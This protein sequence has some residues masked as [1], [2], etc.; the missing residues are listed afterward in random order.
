VR[1]RFVF[2]AAAAVAAVSSV[3]GC[4]DDKAPAK[5]AVFWLG[6]NTASGFT[7]SS[8]QNYQIPE[9]ARSIITSQSAQ[10]ERIKDDAENLVECDVRPAPGSSTDY[11]VSL[12]FSGGPVGNFSAN[13]TLSQDG[14]ELDV[15]FN[16]GMF[17]LGQ[18]NCVATVRTLTAGAI[19]LSALRCNGLRDPSSP[20][21]Q[22]DGQGGVIFEN[23]DR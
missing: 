4:G 3:A 9:G 14:G 5:Q 17:S 11:S 6:L 18:D 1:H 23:C 13:G 12:R 7:C 22:C 21:I 15:D 8:N 16:T 2:L 20:G 19:W 10:G